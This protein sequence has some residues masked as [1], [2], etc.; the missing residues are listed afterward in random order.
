MSL[1]VR[2]P[3]ILF[4]C[5]ANICRSPLAEGMMR[6]RLRD[7][8]LHRRVTVRSAGTRAGQRGMKPD[9]RARRVAEANGISLAGIRSSQVTVRELLR[10]DCIVAMDRANQRDLLEMCPEAHR[11]K[12]HLLTEFAPP[13]A[14]DDIPDPYYGSAEGF[15]EVYRQI[16]SALTGL[17]DDVVQQFG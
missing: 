16:D 17:L 4:V 10:S 11:H 12:I 6:K 13:A 7:M 2:K 5:A 9:L 15:L 1:F 14:G 8:A 3:L